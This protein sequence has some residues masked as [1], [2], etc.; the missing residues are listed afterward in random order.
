MTIK[1]GVPMMLSTVFK[2]IAFDANLRLQLKISQRA[3]HTLGHTFG[4]GDLLIVEGIHRI[5]RR[6]LPK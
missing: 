6:N 3:S 1:K 4:G 2:F 5:C